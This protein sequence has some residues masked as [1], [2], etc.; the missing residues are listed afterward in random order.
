MVEHTSN[1]TPAFFTSS[2]LPTKQGSSASERDKLS[3]RHLRYPRLYI[4][5][6]D[7]FTR[8]PVQLRLGKGI[9][10]N[11]L[12]AQPLKEMHRL[13]V[14]RSFLRKASNSS[15]VAHI[16][17]TIL[18][19]LLKRG[20]SHGHF[21]ISRE[22]VRIPRFWNGTEARYA[23]AVRMRRRSQWN[24]SPNLWFPAGDYMQ[25]EN[26]WENKSF[27]YSEDQKW[28]KS[29]VIIDCG[30]WQFLMMLTRGFCVIQQLTHLIGMNSGGE[31]RWEERVQNYHKQTDLNTWYTASKRH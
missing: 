21:Q 9:G 31:D 2:N 22:S 16:R 4:L 27:N 13:T 5:A 14:A 26:V 12:L 10:G 1:T 8:S 28:A 19:T 23:I 30:T 20:R 29:T 25:N 7:T 17:G 15:S 11:Q 6:V 3:L 24:N 18:Q